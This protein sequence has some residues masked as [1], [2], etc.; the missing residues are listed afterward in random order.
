MKKIIKIVAV[1]M[2]AIMLCL[3]LASCGKTLSGEYRSA[4]VLG[5]YTSYD[6]SA[7]KVSVD[8]YVLGT[9]VEEQS[10]EAKYKIGDGEITFT[11]EDANGDTKTNTQT[12]EELEDGSIKI[13]MVTYEKK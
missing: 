13:G 6:F 1:A 12:F 10:Y 4:E 2:V 8:V 3:C 7:T 11:Y 9:K 5:S